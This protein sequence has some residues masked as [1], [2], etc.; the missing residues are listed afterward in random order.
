MVVIWRI[1]VGSEQT[2]SMVQILAI[3]RKHLKMIL[4]TTLVVTFAVAFVTFFV[5]S[6]KYSATT[7]LLVNRKLSSE[8]Q[9]AQLQQTQADV[10]MINTYKDIITSPTVLKDVNKEVSNY[11]GYPGSIGALKDSISVNSQ[12]NSQVFSVTAKAKDANTAAEIANLTAKVF[13]KKVV[14]IM[15]INNVSIVSEAAVNKNPVS[16]RKTLNLLAGIIVGLLLGIGMAFIRE[17][18]DRTV[19]STDFLTNELGLTSLG[20]VSEIDQGEVKKRIYQKKRLHGTS[21]AGL[22]P[23]VSQRRV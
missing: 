22:N 2:I 20:I 15:S 5:M 8:M 7:E 6:P 12:Q 9:G 17:I 11:P 4:G 18:T 10:Q 16:P 3:L 1:S 21:G 19:S 13:K 14:K 23:Q